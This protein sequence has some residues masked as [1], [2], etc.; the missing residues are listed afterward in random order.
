MMINED[1]IW[2]E[3]DRIY[4]L[5]KGD[6]LFKNDD[7]RAHLDKVNDYSYTGYK[8]KSFLG[9]ASA[10]KKAA[11]KLVESFNDTSRLYDND[12]TLP[13]VFLYRQYLELHLKSL[14]RDGNKAFGN[15]PNSPNHLIDKLW[16]ELKP[17]LIKARLPETY[18]SAKI[19]AV[20]ECIMEFAKVDENSENFRFPVHK[21]TGNPFYKII[22]IY[23]A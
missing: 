10:Y 20:E 21:K 3:Y 9:Y 4:H 8:K 14:V 13:I 7:E 18:N 1:D 2:D 22:H 11:D 15:P 19:E 17:M 5:E 6:T 12:L 16:Q 23:K